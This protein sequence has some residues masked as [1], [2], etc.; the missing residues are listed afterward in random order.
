MELFALANWF[1]RYSLRHPSETPKGACHLFLPHCCNVLSRMNANMVRNDGL[2]TVGHQADSVFGASRGN[3]PSSKCRGWSVT[4]QGGRWVELHAL[5]RENSVV[6]AELP[7]GETKE[8]PVLLGPCRLAIHVPGIFCP[9][10]SS[11]SH[12]PLSRP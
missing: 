4:K 8:C 5:S 9:S 7:S 2:A 10:W 3:T 1:F 6:G 11:F 12:P